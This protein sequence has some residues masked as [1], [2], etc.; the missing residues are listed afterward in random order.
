M[1][2]LTGKDLITVGIFSLIYI[3]LAVVVAC[4]IGLFPVGF[5]LIGFIAPIICGIP[6][7]LYMSKI[8]KFGMLTITAIL[9]GLILALTG[10]GWAALIF[11]VIFAIAAEFI[12]KSGK[13]E[14]VNRSILAYGV[15]SI[16]AAANYIHWI[17][18]SEEWIV[19]RGQTYG[20]EFMRNTAA[21]F[22]H[23]YAM[24]IVVVLCFAGG[25]LGGLL[26][27]IVLKKHFEKSG[28]L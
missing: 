25:I 5:V 6:M 7:I 3:V 24:P 11:G 4:T 9:E 21:F 8:K 23:F 18:A 1:N 17:N 16:A 19:S 10:M 20:E 22:E 12:L 2:K 28:L 26:G 15:F 13:Y 27:K 14:N